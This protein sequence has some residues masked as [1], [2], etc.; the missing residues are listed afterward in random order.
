MLNRQQVEFYFSDSNLHS[1]KFLFTHIEGS[2][3][4]PVPIDVIHKFKRMQR[5]QPRS[6]IISA[7]KESSTLDVVNDDNDIQRKVPLPEGLVGKPLQEIKEVHE[8]KSMAQS[9]YAKG[10]GEEEASSQ[11]D[12]EAFF[13]K[14]GTTNSVRLR[15]DMRGNFKGSVFVEFDT[16]EQ[17]KS[18]LALDPAPKYKDN[19][20]ILKSKKEYCDEKVEDI[21]AGKVRPN[22]PSGSF[23]RKFDGEA[24]DGGERDWRQRRDEESKDGFRSRR[25][26]HRGGHRGS[27]RGRR[28]D[29]G[30]G[31]GRDRNDRGGR[32]RQ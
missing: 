17:A 12:I 11:F 21:K 6:A 29:R 13:A 5:F 19:E 18:F 9:I 32:Q 7:L 27:D 8:N 24:R 4:N 28:G 30:R 23:K 15:R 2:K 31:R 1:D 16:E 10:F 22:S 20:L 25:G 3:N 14:F 26:N